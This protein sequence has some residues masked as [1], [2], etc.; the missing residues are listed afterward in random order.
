MGALL[1][2]ITTE[3]VGTGG[4]WRPGAG[5][6]HADHDEEHDTEGGQHVEADLERVEAGH[7]P[8]PP[9]RKQSAQGSGLPE[10]GPGHPSVPFGHVRT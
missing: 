2:P 3:I 7:D 5:D 1:I 4:V 10:P 6:P 9:S 8:S